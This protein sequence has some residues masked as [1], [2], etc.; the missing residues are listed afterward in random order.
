MSE[1]YVWRD[2]LKGRTMLKK[3][4]RCLWFVFSEHTQLCLCMYL[5][6]FCFLTFLLVFSPLVVS[7]ASWLKDICLVWLPQNYFFTLSKIIS[8]K[9]TTYQ[10]LTNISTCILNRIL[11]V[12]VSKTESWLFFPHPNTWN[13]QNISHCR[14]NNS[15]LF[16]AQA[17]CGIVLRL[18]SFLCHSIYKKISIKSTIQYLKPSTFHTFAGTI[19]V[20]ETIR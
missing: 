4:F 3:V 5:H 8:T 20:Q 6:T 13:S 9:Y 1:V 2:L 11:K 7:L 19:P 18:I 12:Y 14:C 10:W 16:I 15:I 17:K